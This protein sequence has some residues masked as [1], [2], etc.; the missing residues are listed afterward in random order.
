MVLMTFLSSTESTK[1]TAKT[2]RPVTV[3]GKANVTKVREIIESDGRY[4]IRDI[5]KAVGILLSL[6]H[7]IV[8][9][10]LKA[11]KICTRWIPHIDE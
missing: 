5:A 9:R 10:I 11:R 3:T 4:T 1:E 8:K 7:F 2:E 6:V